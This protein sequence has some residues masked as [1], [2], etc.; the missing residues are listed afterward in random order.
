MSKFSTMLFARPSFIEGMARVLDM[1]GTLDSYNYSET[2]EQADFLALFADW[3]S[4]GKDIETA[5]K[6][7][8][9][10]WQGVPSDQAES[11]AQEHTCPR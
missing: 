2:D 7:Y 6:A 5:W 9:S 10:R 4:V 8:A 11:A 3:H 1:G